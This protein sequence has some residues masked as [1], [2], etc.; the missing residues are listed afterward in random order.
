MA[1]CEGMAS[2][3]RPDHLPASEHY[4][5]WLHGYVIFVACATLFLIVA[6]ALVTSNDAG[7]SVPDW[8]TSFGS[9]RMPRMVGGVLY[10][11]GHRMIAATV[12]LLTV[13][14]AVW[15]WLKEPRRWARR[16]ALAAVLAVVAQGVLGGITVLFY[17][18]VAISAGHATLAQTF[19]CIMV[20]LALT[21]QRDWRWTEEKTQKD[22]GTPSL[23]QLTAITTGAIFVQLILGSIY[24]HKGFGVTP[25]IV[26]AT[27][28]AILVIWLVTRVFSGFL[29]LRSLTRATIVLLS[30]LA[31]QIFLGVAAYILKIEFQDAPQPMPFLV[32]VST[33]HVAV[34]ALVLASSLVLTL[35]TFRRVG[36]GNIRA[37]GNRGS[38]EG[39]SMNGV[40]A[41]LKPGA[42]SNL[43]FERW[44]SGIKDYWILT[45]PEVNFLVVVSTLVGYYAAARGPIDWVRLFHT[46]VGTLLVA[47][48]TATLNQLMERKA[49]ALMRR[50]VNRPIPA[51]R[52][53]AVNALGFGVVLSIGG[54]LYLW[55]TVNLLA[56]LL[57]SATLLSYLLIYTPLK[58]RTPWCT[59]IGAFP[60]AM[61]PLIGC[62]GASGHLTR[63]AWV[64]YGILFLWQFPHFLAIAWMYREDYARAGFEMLPREDSEG[65]TTFRKILIYSAVLLPVSLLPTWMGQAGI[66]Y[67]VGAGFLGVMYIYSGTRLAVAKSNA[68]AKRLLLTSVIYLPVVFALLMLDKT[69]A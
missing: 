8:P 19:F 44:V 43:W 68:L 12:G 66:L 36:W 13:V 59:F 56:S 2:E 48:G 52:L 61:P 11:H 24:R 20:T 27:V 1:I 51:G 29:R 16:L 35:Q 67:L 30:L 4:N 53:A 69:A 38:A 9:F 5:P 7:L 47:S 33:A 17:L 55:L 42:G 49:D 41:S 37:S 39:D 32:Q 40:S 25:H 65:R 23:R 10:E 58:K 50:T 6:G 14:L 63:E 22:P 28:V 57:A 54:G 60:G 45:K 34:G 62:A 31:V 3:A 46:L 21:T 15:M 64:L 18:P 26:G